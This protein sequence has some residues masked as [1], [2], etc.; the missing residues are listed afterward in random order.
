ML[1]RERAL[2]QTVDFFT[3]IVDDPFTYGV[4]AAT[5]ALSDV[6]AMGGEPLTAM[7]IVGFPD[8]ELPPEVLTD[9]LKGGLT[10]I[11]EAGAMLVGGHSVR[12]GELKYGLS[13]TGLVHPDRIWRNG[14]ARDGDVLV[15]TKKL[16]TGIL[17]T[18][19]KRDAIPEEALAEAIVSMSTLNQKAAKAGRTVEVHAATD[20]T[21]NGLAGHAWEMA[22][23]SGL[24]LVFR[25]ADLPLFDGVLDLAAAGHCPG[26]AKANAR[27]TGDK[28]RYDALSEAQRSV[29]LDP[30]TSGGLLFAIPARNQA[31]LLSA[32]RD[33]GVPAWVVGSARAGETGITFV[34]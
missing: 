1:D 21:G 12:D 33:L 8:K 4:I 2:V 19:R 32:C 9:I 7:N 3:P 5:N 6:W 27:Y 29:V 15:L 10:K 14:G 22:N 17:T 28:L 11:V 31:A 13:V 20:I 34:P 23:A 24:E 18:A 16:G 30:Q 26:G 25:F